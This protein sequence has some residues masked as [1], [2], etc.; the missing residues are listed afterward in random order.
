MQSAYQYFHSFTQKLAGVYGAD[1]ARAITSYLTAEQLMIKYHQ[2]NVIDKTLGDADIAYFDAVLNRLLNH[3]PLQYIL[4]YAWF[5]GLKFAV[6][7]HVLIPRPETEEL[8]ELVIGHCRMHNLR[9]PVVLDLGTGSGCIPVSIKKNIP[10]ARVFGSDIMDGALEVARQNAWANKV[11]VTFFKDDML[12]P[13]ELREYAPFDIIISNPPYIAE[14]EEA[15]MEP[16][17]KQF[18]PRTALFSPGDPLA[19]YKAIRNI[20]DSYTHPGTSIW[21]ELNPLLV[22][23]TCALFDNE[24]IQPAK[25]I[26]D[27]SGKKRFL[28]RGA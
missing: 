2:L 13:A 25:I 7:G 4:G 19:Y 11:E 28:V 3:E 9:E 14:A 5:C 16:H 1:E 12:N 15:E 17:V 24:T 8:T 21:L 20:S 22:N 26:N 10:G 27:M 18:E 6:N 23:E